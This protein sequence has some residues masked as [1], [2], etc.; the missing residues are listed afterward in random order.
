MKT[1]LRSNFIAALAGVA[2]TLH[3]QI[4]AAPAFA[5][6]PAGWG[7]SQYVP[8]EVLVKFKPSAVAQDRAASIA[9]QG[10][11]FVAELNQPGVARIRLGSGQT[12]ETALAAYQGDPNVEYA[13]PNYI[14]HASAVPPSDTQYG[15]LWAFKNTGQTITGAN[16]L[17]AS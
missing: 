14:Y 7:K 12:V 17:P 16:F 2:L 6:A 9:A 11:T 8:G 1:L 5:P 4:A 13:Q 3:A 15:Q 10:H